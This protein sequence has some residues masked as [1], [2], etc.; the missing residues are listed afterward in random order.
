M[1]KILKGIF[2]NYFQKVTP[3][4]LFKNIYLKCNY[5][6]IIVNILNYNLDFFFLHL[7]SVIRNRRDINNNSRVQISTDRKLL[8]K[9][10]NYKKI[11]KKSSLRGG[12]L[13]RDDLSLGYL[14]TICVSASQKLND[15]IS[16]KESTPV[17]RRNLILHESEIVSFPIHWGILKG[18]RS[19]K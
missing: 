18:T 8:I 19:L 12:K 10:F 17:S 15:S 5:F 9:Y 2:V 4:I 16:E 6:K 13:Q 1:Y 14:K 3:K 11:K 7:F